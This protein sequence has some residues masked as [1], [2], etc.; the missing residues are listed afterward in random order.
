MARAL[1]LNGLT[2][3]IT[4]DGCYRRLY[5]GKGSIGSVNAI[6]I[7]V[8]GY[9]DDNSIHLLDKTG[10]P[11]ENLIIVSNDYVYDKADGV[12]VCH[13]LDRSMLAD[14]DNSDDD[15]F[16]IPEL[17]KRLAEEK[18]QAE[19]GA[20]KTKK[21]KE[22]TKEEPTETASAEP[23]T[24]ELT[25]KEIRD[26]ILIPEGMKWAEVQIAYEAAPKRGMP[27][28]QLKDGLVKYVFTC[29]EQKRIPVIADKNLNSIIAK[30]VSEVTD[31]NEKEMNTLLSRE[32]GKVSEKKKK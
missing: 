16:V 28:I 5:H 19:Q 8:S 14:E 6:D 1:S 31:L 15:D 25:E 29:E 24:P 18:L 32:E 3:I 12:I 4:D 11:Y 7:A 27:G 20:K 23:E 13:A 22:E 21:S 17:E 26:K 2:G 30:L 9:I 10:V